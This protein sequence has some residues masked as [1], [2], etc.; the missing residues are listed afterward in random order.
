MLFCHVEVCVSRSTLGVS[1]EIGDYLR[2]FGTRESEVLAGLRE[3]TAAL[4]QAR[5]QISPEQ[6]QLMGLLV[7]LVGAR[8]ILEVGTFTGYSA[9]VMAAAMPEGGTLLACDVSE[10]WT[11]IGRRYWEQAGVADRIDLRI[12]PALD[13]LDGLVEAGQ[14]GT[15][16][17]AFV[18]ADKSNYV[19][20]WERVVQLVR[21]GGLVLID[22]VLWG[23]RVVDMDDDSDDTRAIRALNERVSLDERVTPALIPIGDG[24]TV[25]RVRQPR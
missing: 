10:E 8:R 13:T 6:G 22:N 2:R 17:L 9:L 7:E 19:A 24:L 25:A 3:E 21:P 16:D 1:P 18:D 5:M 11:A 14:A 23:G 12:G 15:W 20:Y 4:P